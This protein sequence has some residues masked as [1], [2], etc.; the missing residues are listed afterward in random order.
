MGIEEWTITS[1][2]RYNSDFQQRVVL[3]AMYIRD[4]M[5]DQEC[6]SRI[7]AKRSTTIIAGYIIERQRC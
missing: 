3:Y 5:L 4:E 1:C 6:M 7:S 2:S